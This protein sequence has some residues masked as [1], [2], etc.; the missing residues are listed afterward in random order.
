MRSLTSSNYPVA[1]LS[2]SIF[3][4]HSLTFNISPLIQDGERNFEQFVRIQGTTAK[5]F[6]EFSSHTTDEFPIT[7][8]GR[9][10]SQCHLNCSSHGK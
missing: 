6:R 10:C 1:A 4:M 8:T 2:A 9:Q 5:L 7:S 3:Y